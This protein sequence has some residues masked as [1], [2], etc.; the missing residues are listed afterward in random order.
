MKLI[1]FLFPIL[2]ISSCSS[3]KKSMVYGGLSGG[4]IGAFAGSSLSPDSYSKT[5]NAL[6]WGGVG[7]AL[8]SALGYFFFNDDPENRELPQMILKEEKRMNTSED[9]A[10]PVIIPSSATKYKVN[11]APLPEALKGKV[12]R[13][14]IIEMTIPERIQKL[15]NGRTLVIEEHKATEIVYE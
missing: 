3:L 7:L 4:A 5:P 15:E 12:P 11:D 1:I 13:P 14:S 6:I 2:L 9:F 10:A 8:G